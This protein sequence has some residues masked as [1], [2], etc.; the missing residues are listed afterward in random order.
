MLPGKK[1]T[2]EDILQILRKNIW[3]IL[4]PVAVVSA[5]TAVVARKLPDRYKA[6]ALVQV[7]PQQVPLDYVRPT[8]SQRLEDRLNSISATVQSRTRLER[9][10]EELNLYP[11][12]RRT[13]IMED[14]VDQMRRDIGV[15]IS[16]D[17]FVVFCWGAQAKMTAVVANK[18]ASAYIDE[19]LRDRERLTQGTRQFMEG[20][21]EEARQGLITQE[22]KLE[23]YRIRNAGQLPN[24]VESNLH[25]LQNV[26]TQTQNLLESI[27]RA[28]DHRLLLQTELTNLQNG[29][30]APGAAPAK[31]VATADA[32]TAPAGSTASQ[33]AF[34]KNVL[35]A[36][37][38]AGMTPD[39]PDVKEA[40]RLIRET[41]DKFD[42]EQLDRPVSADDPDDTVPPAEKAR[43]QRIQQDQE[44]LAQLTKQI[45]GYKAEQK[46]LQGIAAMYQQRIDTVPTRESE[47]VELTRDYGTL[48]NLY[49]GLLTKK[50][51]STL[52]ATLEQRQIGEQFK[53]LEQALVPLR[54]TSPNRPVITM[55]GMAAGLAIGLAIVALMVYRDSTF[56]SDSEITDL[57]SLPVLAVVPLME[58][59]AER[60]RALRRRVAIYGLCG[61]TVAGCLSVLVY[62]FVR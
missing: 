2:P 11:E 61:C 15:N 14:V 38:A 36:R 31:P 23:D 33:L 62:T 40:Q 30:P 19:S 4:V 45:D 58:S 53:I 8:V 17:T 56:K 48:Q 22:K 57:L 21:V 12:E 35:A 29:A 47:M 7:V 34:W 52:S 27:N 5:V 44:A 18:L 42:K 24:Q 16:G 54:P 55:G 3:F 49:V 20:Q 28:D 25:A 50:E 60:R 13:G 26:Q 46:R 32:T 10:I 1:F 41:Q 39:H 43:L 9:I 37:L 59:D 51:D 6:T